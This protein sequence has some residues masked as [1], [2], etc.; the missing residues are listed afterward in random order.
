MTRDGGDSAE[1]VKLRR[2]LR[3]LSKRD[4]AA[5]VN[6]H[7]PPPPYHRPRP[8][9]T[10]WTTTAS[11]WIGVTTSSRPLLSRPTATRHDSRP[12]TAPQRTQRMLR[13]RSRWAATTRMSVS[14]TLITLPSRSPSP[15]SRPSRNPP[16]PPRMEVGA[17]PSAKPPHCPGHLP[18][19][20]TRSLLLET[21]DRLTLKASPLR[22]HSFMGF[23]RS[24]PL[25]L[26]SSNSP[27]RRGLAQ[28]PWRTG[29]EPM[30]RL[31]LVMETTL[32]LQTGRSGIL[33][34][35]VKMP[36][37]TTP[38][39][40]SRRGQGLDLRPLGGPHQRRTAAL[41]PLVVSLRNSWIMVIPRELGVANNRVSPGGTPTLA[42]VH[43]LP[44]RIFRIRTATTDRVRPRQLLPRL[45]L[46]IDAVTVG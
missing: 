27:L 36:T 13:T 17:T 7:H 33:E 1:I 24:L 16:P 30:A 42:E 45:T 41:R 12:S 34:Q 18:V 28:A 23:L 44:T 5:I 4:A 6:F 3:E 21:L 35:V 10:W 38:R 9:S 19:H 11:A 2:S 46:I 14:T 25:S 8:R 40:M 37:I 31:A 22:Y 43:L 32:Y 29:E 15:A 20:K 39:R 26:P